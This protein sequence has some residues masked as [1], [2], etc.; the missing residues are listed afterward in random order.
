MPDR[1]LREVVTIDGRNVELHHDTPA[2]PA[3]GDR[4]SAGQEPRVVRLFDPALRPSNTERADGKPLRLFD[5]P[6][7]KVEVSKR[8]VEDMSFW[9]RNADCHELILCLR[10]RL[11]WETELGT[12][13]LEP[14]DLL[15][16][17][18]GIAHRSRL[19]PGVEGNNVLLELKVA[20]ELGYV[21]DGQP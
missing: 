2:V 21:G 17:P 12:V 4:P 10:G 18:R 14:G 8:N 15:E 7:V 20:G 11:T 6:G 5:S 16:I 3:D 13:T 9:H 1:P 19:A